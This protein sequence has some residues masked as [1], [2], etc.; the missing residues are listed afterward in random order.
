MALAD[1]AD[2]IKT[3]QEFFE[4]LRDGLNQIAGMIKWKGPVP[5]PP[6]LA[7]KIGTYVVDLSYSYT[8]LYF[9]Y[10]ASKQLKAN[11]DL[12]LRAFVSMRQYMDKL[13]AQIAEDKEK[14][15]SLQ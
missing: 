15:K 2:D 6:V 5:P 12:Q 4:V 10:D 14:L 1:S 7:L 3:K 13:L 11:Q 8:Q 9:T